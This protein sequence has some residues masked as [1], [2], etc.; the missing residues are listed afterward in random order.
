MINYSACYFIV[1]SVIRGMSLELGAI[2]TIAEGLDPFIDLFLSSLID[3][4]FRP[5]I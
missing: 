2:T 3:V 1:A 5:Y 4:K